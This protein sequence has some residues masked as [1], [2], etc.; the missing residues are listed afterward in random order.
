MKFLVVD[1]HAL[2]RE[3]LRGVLAELRTD[4]VVLEAPSCRRALDLI[5]DHPDLS[6]ILLD[7]SAARP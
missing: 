6:L 2:I 4:A 5:R 3:A 7:H 1:D